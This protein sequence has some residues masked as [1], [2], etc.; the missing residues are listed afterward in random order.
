MRC[1]ES[2]YAANVEAVITAAPDAAADRGPAGGQGARHRRT[3]RPSRRWWTGPTA[4]ASGARSRAADTLKNVL[5]KVRAPGGEWELLAIGVPGD[6]EV[7]EKR[8][9]AA[10]DPAEYA[11]LDDADFAKNPFLVKGYVGPKGVAG[12]RCSLPGRPAD[13]RRHGVDH[14]RRRPQQARRRPG[15]WAA[16]SPP[17][18]P[19]RPP[20]SAT[21]T[22]P[23]TARA[24]WCRPV[25]SRSAT[26]SSWAAS[27]PTRFAVDVL[28]EDGK[29]VRLTMGSY[30]IGVSRLVA[31]IAEQHH[32]ELGLRW[33]SS[34]SPF[35]VHVVIANKDDDARAGAEELAAELDRLGVEVLLDDRQGLTRREVQGRRTARGAVDRG[36]RARLGRRRRR[37]AQPVQRRERARSP[38]TVRPPRSPRRSPLSGERGDYSVPPGKAT[39]TGQTP[40]T[41]LQRAAVT[42]A[43]RQRLDR[44]RA[45]LGRR[46]LLEH[47]PPRH[48]GVLL[49][50]HREVRRIGRVVHLRRQLIAGRGQRRVHAALR[51]HLDR[52]L[53]TF[54][55]LRHRRSTPGRCRRGSNAPTRAR[56]RRWR[57]VRWSRRRTAPRHR[58]R[59]SGRAGRF[60]VARRRRRRGSADVTVRR[61]RTQRH[62][63]GRRA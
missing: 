16:T 33:P 11:L 17:T 3:R 30:G 5:L 25:A 9:G 52:G 28:G 36:G 2:G 10:L 43:L 21:A 59:R 4:P 39:V 49:H 47:R 29:P 48:G 35:D 12:Q 15:R 55:V 19:S 20:R 58:R 34:V 53:A 23:R 24:R 61:P 31:V 18:A 56:S 32:D 62:R 27:T 63:V 45:L 38:S 6:R 26:S 57:R 42:A 41:R 51:E 14:R 22:R 7:D 1:L 44:E 8:L 60:C 46:R 54:A 13:R 50:P 40:S 37:A